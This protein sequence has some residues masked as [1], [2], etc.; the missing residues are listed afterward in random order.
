MKIQFNRLLLPCLLIVSAV[1]F[2]YAGAR[3]ADDA[4]DKTPLTWLVRLGPL[5]AS[6][7]T[8]AASFQQENP[9]IAL[10]LIWVP[11]GQYQTKFKTLAAAGLAPDVFNTGDV[12]VAYM[13]PFLLDLTDLVARDRDEID[14][15][16]FFP[17][18]VAAMQH[19]ERYYFLATHLNVSLLYYNKTLFDEMNIAYPTADWTW[20]DYV[21]V[22]AALT[23]V[24]QDG[25]KIWGSDMLTGWWGEWLIF[26][27]QAGGRMFNDDCSRCLLDTP[28]AIR[29]VQFYYDK[30]YKSGMSPRPGYG[31][32]TRFAS[33][34][35]AMVWGG[36]MN[37]WRTYNQIEDL[38]WDIQI[39]PRGPVTRKGGEIAVG[40]YGI[41][42]QS[43][44]PEAAWRLVKHLA[45]PEAVAEEAKFGGFPTRKSVADELLLG[46]GRNA[47]PATVQAVYAQLP[48]AHPIPRSPNYIELAIEVIQPEMDRMLQGELT[49]EQACR[50]AAAAANRFID[51]LGS[52]RRDL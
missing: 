45:T 36:H 8:L 44:H 12:W 39:L 13:L 47:R 42:K 48:H 33:G 41:N 26:V 40:A 3:T 19:K 22:G 35:M 1:G 29:G 30:V 10:R 51:V 6:Y 31:P 17:E 20:E 27:R 21:K 25:T 38:Q 43:R 50:R 9:D 52:R 18:V 34:M 24:R 2:W 49:P 4:G 14:L 15:D 11:A 23:W 28:E 5:K 16:D 37:Y 7:E 46:P 32:A